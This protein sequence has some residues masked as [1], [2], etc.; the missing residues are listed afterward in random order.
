VDIEANV[1]ADASPQFRAAADALPVAMRE[2]RI[3][4]AAMGI[5][6][7]GREE[8]ATFGLASLASERPV[9]GETLFQIASVTKTYTATVIWRLI[10]QGSLSLDAPVR[11]YLPE[12]RLSDEA[13][14]ETVTVANLLE[15]TAGWFSDEVIDGGNDDAAL[16]RFVEQRLPRQP[17]LFTCGAHFSYSNSAFQL[18]GRLIEVITGQTYHGALR[19]LLFEPL[20]VSDTTLDR[21]A[22]LGRLYADGHSAIPVNG[23]DAVLVQTPVWLP[24]CVDPAGGIWSTTRDVLRYVR[25]HLGALGTDATGLLRPQTLGAM[26][27]PAV[28]VPG[29]GLHMGRSWFV[30]EVAG[31]RV[32]SHNGDTS[33]QHAVLLA[34]PEHGFAFVVLLNGQPGAAAALAALDAALSGYPGLDAL[35]GRVGLM[36]SLLAPADADVISLTEEQLQAYAGRYVDP[37]QTTTLRIAGQS[38][39]KSSELTPAPGAWRPAFAAPPAEPGPVTF[40]APDVAIA[41]GMRIPF[42]RRDDGSVGWL[43]EGL[44]LRPRVS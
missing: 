36:R 19:R 15:H 3:P 32:I 7:K 12:L 2:A 17:Q 44:R 40:T 21:S 25:T 4:G 13:T 28:A 22:V 33:G 30:Q 8:H 5:L 37:G 11:R 16:A 20:G 43:A 41:G 42:V 18:L 34:V 1:T 9:E 23:Q 6:A 10:D 27:E 24:R 29:L 38:L 26:Q 39:E 14:A 31:L 35:A